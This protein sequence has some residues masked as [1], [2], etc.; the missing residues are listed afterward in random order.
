MS[1][2]KHLESTYYAHGM[3]WLLRGRYK[4]NIEDNQDQAFFPTLTSSRGSKLFAQ[5]LQGHGIGY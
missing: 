5:I 2:H 4:G 3:C 1:G